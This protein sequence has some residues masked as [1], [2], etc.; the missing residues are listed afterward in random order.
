MAKGL[1]SFASAFLILLCFKVRFCQSFPRLLTKSQGN[2]Y[3]S[4]LAGYVYLG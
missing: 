4:A 3:A 1:V 2:F